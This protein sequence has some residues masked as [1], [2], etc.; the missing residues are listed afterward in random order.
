MRI[1]LVGAFDRNNYGDVLMPIIM[2]KQIIKNLPNLNIEFEYYGQSYSDMKD[3]CAKRTIPLNNIYSNPCDIVIVVGGQVLSAL[4]TGMYLNLQTSS[5]E[6][7]KYKILNKFFKKYTEKKC[8]KKLKGKSIKPWILDK[9]DIKCKKLIY[10]TVGGN[11]LEGISDELIISKV[12]KKIDY[13]SIREKDSFSILKKY[14]EDSLLY[15]DSII[16]LSSYMEENEIYGNVRKEIKEKVSNFG[17]Y[18]VFQIKNNY[19]RLYIN[20]IVKQIK[21]T[22]RKTSLKCILLPIGYAQGHEDHII[23][24]KIYKLLDEDSCY[25][26]YNNNIYETIYIIKNSKFFAGTSLHGII[27]AISYNIPNIIVTTHLSKLNSFVKTWN[28]TMI[29]N[30]PIEKISHNISNIMKKYDESK[31]FTRSVNKRLNILVEENFKK[32]NDIIEE[33]SKYEC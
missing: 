8:K 1:G 19:G 29:P 14:K 13:I 5:T 11:V 28:T 33:C 25:M 3:L 20:E 23:L 4:Y 2:E 32:I 30:T 17:R 24:K 12:V 9:D 27:T 26:P 10:N 31:E 16:N 15:P 18:F 7:F 22:I 21:D 6:I